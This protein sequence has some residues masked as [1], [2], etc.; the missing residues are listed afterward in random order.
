MI[1]NL[2][3]FDFAT[4]DGSMR[5]ASRHPG[6]SADEIVEQTG[7]PLAIEGDVPETRL[8]SDAELALVRERIDPKG[9]VNREV[10]V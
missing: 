8:P 7:F 9:L 10:P 5:L 3:V 4:P 6:V 1:S 2:G